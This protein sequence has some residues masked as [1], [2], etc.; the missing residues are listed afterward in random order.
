MEINTLAENC[1]C[2]WHCHR[3][4]QWINKQAPVWRFFVALARL[5]MRADAVVPLRR[6]Y[7]G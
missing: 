3:F 4:R 2:G 5:S 1:G 7:Q 6:R